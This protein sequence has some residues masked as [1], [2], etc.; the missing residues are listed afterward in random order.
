MASLR[1]LLAFIILGV[2]SLA[3]EALTNQPAAA[4]PAL[5]RRVIR[6]IAAT[7]AHQFF[8]ATVKWTLLGGLAG[9]TL[10]LVWIAATHAAGLF[11]SGWRYQAWVRWLLWILLVLATTGALAVAGFWKGVVRGSEQ[12]LLHSQIGT[13]ALPLVGQVA[14]DGM[15][16][17][18]LYRAETNRSA[19]SPKELNRRLEPFRDG[20]WEV[21]APA[22]ARDLHLLPAEV[23]TNLLPQLWREAVARVPQLDQNPTRDFFLRGVRLLEGALSG[24]RLDGHLEQAGASP[25]LKNLREKLVAEAA[26]TGPP[27]SIGRLELAAF[28]VQEGIVPAILV[29][30]RSFARSQ[31]NLC[32]FGAALALVGAPLLFRF[33]CGRVRDD[34]PPCFV[35][36]APPILKG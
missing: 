29:P 32:L 24:N 35:P 1:V 26:R 34:V 27:E 22:F 28:V 15:A 7:Q 12:V 13:Q 2:A 16:A 17:I 6:E 11:R 23:A 8:L 31:R 18:Q 3:A 19:W 36:P 10:S 9:V 25:F 20:A 5:T 30:I 14:A 21:N 4:N 33:T